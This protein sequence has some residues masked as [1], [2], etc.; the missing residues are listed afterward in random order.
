MVHNQGPSSLIMDLLLS[1]TENSRHLMCFVCYCYKQ[2]IH[3]LCKKDI[4]I[5]VANFTVLC[6]DWNDLIDMWYEVK[7]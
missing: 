2:S 1:L 3:F 6:N 5:N 4:Y 7:Q